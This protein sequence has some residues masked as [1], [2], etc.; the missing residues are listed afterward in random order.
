MKDEKKAC[1]ISIELGGFF[2]GKCAMKTK[3]D[4]RKKSKTSPQIPSI[5]EPSK[6]D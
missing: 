3:T 2:N 6:G 5:L 4:T 1:V